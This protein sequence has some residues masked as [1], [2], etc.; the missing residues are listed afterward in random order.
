MNEDLNRLFDTMAEE[1]KVVEGILG[2][3]TTSYFEEG[4]SL[5][6]L[7]LTA[8]TIDYGH[9]FSNYNPYSSRVYQQATKFSTRGNNSGCKF[10]DRLIMKLV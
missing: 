6:C 8:L 1:L 10:L 7:S 5:T 4:Q 2:F 9:S 3:E